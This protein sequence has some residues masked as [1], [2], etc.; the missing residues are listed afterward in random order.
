VH[1][2]VNSISDGKRCCTI[3]Q[4]TAAHKEKNLQTQHKSTQHVIWKQK[5]VIATVIMTYSVSI[6]VLKLNALT[7]ALIITLTSA[8]STSDETTVSSTIA[9][10]HHCRTTDH[11][12]I[13]LCPHVLQAH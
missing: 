2:T 11:L 1:T 13:F 5:L 4:H 10:L 7:A 12:Y 8:T 3:S 6:T 9:S